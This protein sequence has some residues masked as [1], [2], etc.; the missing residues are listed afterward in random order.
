MN[1]KRLENDQDENKNLA[2]WVN[3]IAAMCKPQSIQWCD[4]SAEEYDMLAN[5]LVNNGTF[6]KL[7]EKLR[8]NSYCAM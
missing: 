3:E 8:P 6:I 5:L 7:N 2:A 4:G 1:K